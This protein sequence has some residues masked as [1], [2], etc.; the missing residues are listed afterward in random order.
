VESKNGT[1]PCQ[2]GTET[3]SL[4]ISANPVGL[5]LRVSVGFLWTND[6]DVDAHRGDGKQFVVRAHELTR[7]REWKAEVRRCF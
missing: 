5:G 4:N 2:S 7:E 1:I 6:L 3:L